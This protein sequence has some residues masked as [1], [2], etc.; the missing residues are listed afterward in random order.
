[1][2]VEYTIPH[3]AMFP[4]ES[5][6]GGGTH[7]RVLSFL[8]NHI[9][10]NTLHSYGELVPLGCLCS[11]PWRT[12]YSDLS[13]RKLLASPPPLDTNSVEN[14]KIIGFRQARP[15]PS[16]LAWSLVVVLPT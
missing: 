14:N 1:M 6:K 9:L 12:P 2:R 4:E 3:E 8:L 11:P 13:W 16:V 15:R 7:G 5:P 10:S